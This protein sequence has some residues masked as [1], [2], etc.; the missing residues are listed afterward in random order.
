M[1]ALLW[2]TGRGI[3]GF[4]WFWLVLAVLLDLT[5]WAASARG[6]YEDRDRIPGYSPSMTA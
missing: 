4:D 1:Y 3:D 2:A 6:A 5:H